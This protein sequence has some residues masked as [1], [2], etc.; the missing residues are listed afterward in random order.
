MARMDASPSKSLSSSPISNHPFPITHCQ[1]RCPTTH[2]QSPSP[3]ASSPCWPQPCSTAMLTLTLY[4]SA[5][6]QNPKVCKW[7]G[8]SASTVR[9]LRCWWLTVSRVHEDEDKEWGGMC[10]CVCTL[11]RLQAC[12]ALCTSS[13]FGCNAL[14][15]ILC[16]NCRQHQARHELVCAQQCGLCH[17]LCVRDNVGCIVACACTTVRTASW[18]V[19]A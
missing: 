17:G 4:A 5:G 11:L 6:M 7:Q 16:I 19:C 3:I 9:S 15:S 1:S 8:Q 18:L 10:V 2:C 14:D 12:H 13:S